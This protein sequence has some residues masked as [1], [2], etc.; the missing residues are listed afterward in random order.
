MDGDNFNL[1]S[2]N[3]NQ[4]PGG[5][6]TANPNGVQDQSIEEK[7]RE[8]QKEAVL[9]QA[10][11]QDALTRLRRIKLVKKDKAIAVE[12]LITSMAMQGKLPGQINEGR[13]INMLE[14]LGAKESVSSSNKI[15]IQ[16]KK[17]AFDSDDDDDDNFT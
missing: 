8:A 11:T 5:F 1:S 12:N 7:Q 14:G 17:Y 16:R 9:E 2:I 3:Q 6:T 4:L 10:L 15:S 13:L